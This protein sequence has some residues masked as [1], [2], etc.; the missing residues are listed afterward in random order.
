M[1]DLQERV[2]T[3]GH[4]TFDDIS[5]WGDNNLLSKLKDYEIRKDTEPVLLIRSDVPDI[6]KRSFEQAREC[7]RWGLYGAC[8]GLCRIILDVTVRVIDE[9]KRNA[10]PVH[11]EFGPLLN[12]IP[13][14]L[15]NESER[16]SVSKFWTQASNFLHG[17]GPWPGKDEAWE[18]LHF[19]AIIVD[20]LAGRTAFSQR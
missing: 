15:L 12:C 20:H 1:G 2:N 5:R 17:K 19:T 18:S 4:W 16:K 3:S 14:N 8:F 13:D 9:T 7:Y 10:I 11:D 6:I